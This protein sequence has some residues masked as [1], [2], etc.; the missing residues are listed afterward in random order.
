MSSDADKINKQKVIPYQFDDEEINDAL[1]EIDRMSRTMVVKCKKQL[2][3]LKV[4]LVVSGILLTALFEYMMFVSLW[5]MEPI[6]KA[7]MIFT[8]VFIPGSTIIAFLSKYLIM[9]LRSECITLGTTDAT[10]TSSISS[11]T[12]LL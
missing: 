11:G 7:V 10:I 12:I 9:A 3:L 4:L 1:A 6:F 2:L 8:P 5:Y